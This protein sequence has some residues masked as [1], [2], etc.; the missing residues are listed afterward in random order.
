ML[1]Q[2]LAGIRVLDITQNVAGP[3]CTQILGDLGAEVIKLERPGGGDDA[4]DW[5]PPEIGGESATFLALNRNKRSICVDLDAAEGQ[6]IVRDLARSIDVVIHSMKPGSAEQRGIG[7]ADLARVNPALIYCPISAFG[8]VGPLRG[9]PGYDPLMQAFTG[10][11][12]TTG[13]DGEDPVRVAVSLIDMGTGVWAAL[14]ILAALTQ[15]A[16]TGRGTLVETSLME[17]GVC[18]M[19]IFVATYGATGKLPRKMGSAM[20][21]TAPYELFRTADGHVFV[22]AGNDRLFARVCQGLGIGGLASDPR[23][24]TN[25]LRVK[26]RDALHE[27]IEAVTSRHPAGV[28]VEKLRRAGAPCSQL[29]SVA[30]VLDHEQVK[31]AGIIADLP[32]HDAPG[33]RVVALPLKADGRRSARMEPPPVLGSD[34]DPVLSGLGYAP[35]RLAA[36]RRAGTIA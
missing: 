5:R 15:R 34:T 22:A 18:W 1:E 17:T 11:M 20:S 16:K 31:A 26:H 29:N 14:G 35:E 33:H 10:I 13:R 32:L 7:H 8:Q 25:P 27:A 3:Y 4:R 6:E 19:T 2:T 21:I 12:S 28:V 9:L 23:F 30:D 24:A 36:L